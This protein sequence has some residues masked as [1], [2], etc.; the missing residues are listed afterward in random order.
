[1][2]RQN[3]SQCV[4]GRENRRNV[5][6]GFRFVQYCFDSKVSEILG[7]KNQSQNS[8]VNKFF[9]N[10]QS[11]HII[12]FYSDQ[13]YSGKG[14]GLFFEYDIKVSAVFFIFLL[15]MRKRKVM[16]GVIPVRATEIKKRDP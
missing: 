9:I 13:V 8:G 5:C 15:V 2:K 12:L 4:L 11:D 1:M 6:L 16:T 10:F 7:F 14:V 3:F